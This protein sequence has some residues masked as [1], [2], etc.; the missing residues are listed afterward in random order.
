MRCTTLSK[1]QNTKISIYVH[2]IKVNCCS[3][4]SSYLYITEELSNNVYKFYA[5]QISHYFQ[6]DHSPYLT[7]AKGEIFNPLLQPPTTTNFKLLQN[8]ETKIQQG[9]SPLVI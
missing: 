6:N 7:A 9:S 1:P 8:G 2:N 4:P 3:W 5:N